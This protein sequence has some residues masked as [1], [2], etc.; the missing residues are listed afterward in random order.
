MLRDKIIEK[1]GD[2]SNN[3][4]KIAKYI[5][6][7]YSHILTLSST[8]LAKITGVSNASVVRFAKAMGYKGFLA[9]R[10]D[11]KDESMVMRSPYAALKN[12]PVNLD[13]QMLHKYFELLNNDIMQFA[14]TI[15]LSVI[16]KIA[17]NVLNARTVYLYGIGTDMVLANYL[18]N[19]L[20][21][22]GIH[23]VTVCE[24]GLA[25]RDKAI[26][27][28]KDDYVI[29]SSF[30]DIQVDEYWL[31]NYIHEIGADI[32][33]ITDSDVT[34]SDLKC[35]TYIVTKG[36]LDT[37]Y[38]SVVISMVLCDILLLKIRER[39]PERAEHYMKKYDSMTIEISNNGR[40]K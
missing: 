13:D 9:F 28:S 4:K 1:Y 8:D 33:L 20:P 19:Y 5:V 25:M 14:D 39:D 2:F 31:V 38:N 7:N 18:N 12:T 27:M 34:A 15:D 36:S 22:L 24:E 35:D 6:D 10:N 3:E 32:A 30:P 17:D 37:F 23:S 11:L 16:E 40:D 26:M 21:L 29:M